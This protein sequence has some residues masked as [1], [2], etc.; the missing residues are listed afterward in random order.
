MGRGGAFCFHHLWAALKRPILN[1]VNV[2]V[3]DLVWVTCL[4]QSITDCFI[5][6]CKIIK[7]LILY[8]DSGSHGD[9]S[10]KVFGSHKRCYHNEWP[11]TNRYFKCFNIQEWW[12]KNHAIYHNNEETSLKNKEAKPVQPVQVVM[13]WQFCV[14]I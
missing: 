2:I 6:S 4:L 12:K 14:L 11:L 1:K 13:I 10:A 3:I 5:R 7:N 9:C 8:L